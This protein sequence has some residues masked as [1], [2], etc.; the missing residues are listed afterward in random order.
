MK[1][2]SWSLNVSFLRVH[3]RATKIFLALKGKLYICHYVSEMNFLN[4]KSIIK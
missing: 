2:V 1:K 4:V 3:N